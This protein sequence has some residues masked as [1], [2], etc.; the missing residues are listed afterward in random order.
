LSQSCCFCTTA[1]KIPVPRLVPIRDRCHD[2]QSDHLPLR[3]RSEHRLHVPVS[4]LEYPLG[5]RSLRDEAA[6]LESYRGRW[7][8]RLDRIAQVLE[9]RRARRAREE[10]RK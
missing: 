5:R 3:Q 10:K 7:E 1:A 4:S 9:Q 8:K 6:W 2:R